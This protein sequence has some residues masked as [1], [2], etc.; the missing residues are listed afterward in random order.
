MKKIFIFKLCCLLL[1][2]AGVK[3]NAQSGVTQ[4]GEAQPGEA[5]SA[6]VEVETGFK[7]VDGF[8][9]FLPEGYQDGEEKEWPLIFFLHGAGE[10]G[11]SLALVKKHG[12]LKMAEQQADFPFIVV[13][14]QCPEGRWWYASELKV[15]LDKV[16][17]NYRVDQER[18]YLTGLSMGGYGS[19]EMAMRYPHMFAAVAPVCGGGNPE[20]VCRMQKLPVWNF[21]GAKDPVVPLAASEQMVYALQDCGTEVRFTVYPE[22]EHEAWEPAYS[23]PELYSWFLEHKRP[24]DWEELSR[25]SE[26]DENR[27]IAADS[28]WII[29]T[30][31]S[32]IRMWPDIQEDFKVEKIL[33]RG[34]GG[35]QIS[36]LLKHY[37]KLILQYKPR[38]VVVYSGDND[39]EAGKSPERVAADVKVLHHQLARDLPNTSFVFIS[40]KPS[41]ARAA[42]FD[43]MQEANRLIREY[44]ETQPNA[45]Y[46]DVTEAMMKNGA[47][48][49][50]AGTSARQI[51]EDLFLEDG[52]HMNEKGYRIWREALQPYIK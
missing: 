7:A 14:P 26:E 36:D 1:I 9:L 44:L 28:G 41:L 18:V 22:V 5:Q 42:K 27:H 34:F 29:F 24:R 48:P 23:N 20:Q 47:S 39:I 35:S 52:L 8:M 40:I 30:G 37:D 43:K 4:P 25:F 13:A 45:R 3:S 21:H 51:R 10:R 15:L 19:W 2:M 46:V 16:I 17:S 31:S 11:D 38:Q 6:M 32:S 49:A 12:P 50:G 33:N